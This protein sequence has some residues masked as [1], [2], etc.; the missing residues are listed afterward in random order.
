MSKHKDAREE[1]TGAKSKWSVVGDKR[2]RSLF[3]VPQRVILD[4]VAKELIGNRY[5]RVL[6]CPAFVYGEGES[7]I[8]LVAHSDTVHEGDSDR[9]GNFLLLQRGN[10]LWS[11]YGLGADDRAGIWAIMR[12]MLH[13]SRPHILVTTDEERGGKGAERAG[14][15]F[16]P[17]GVRLMVELDRRG[18]EDAVYYGLNCPR[19]EKY[20]KTFGYTRASGSYSDISTLMDEWKIPGVNLSVGYNWE[21]STREVLHISALNST[22]DAVSRLLADP[23]VPEFEYKDAADSYRNIGSWR[24]PG[25]DYYD[26]YNKYKDN[27]ESI[28]TPISKGR[29]TIMVPTKYNLNPDMITLGIT[30]DPGEG[31]GKDLGNNAANDI[32]GKA[33][34]EVAKH[35]VTQR[36]RILDGD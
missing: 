24:R 9:A 1:G 33:A 12:L 20:I 6:H 14:R 3:S 36:R 27:K 31:E 34:R 4:T 19:L 23:E 22:I 5:K 13:P 11:P 25:G 28:R 29:S 32:V 21:H 26:G 7:P 30:D 2:L 15:M 8:M 35:F 10:I 17:R 16:R 18:H